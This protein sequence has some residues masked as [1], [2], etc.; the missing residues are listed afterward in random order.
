MTT[1][2]SLSVTLLQNL[3]KL[4][5]SFSVPPAHPG[6]EG[7]FPAT[8]ILPGFL[9]IQAA[10]ELLA[11][12]GTHSRLASVEAAK[13]TRAIHPQEMVLVELEP[14][15]TGMFEAVLT[16]AGTPTSRFTLHVSPQMT[17]P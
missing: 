7:H 1:D 9:H 11:A 10:L 12:A 14:V 3:P 13:F 8:P 6:F 4:R 2:T 15:G 5:G 17:K 16:V